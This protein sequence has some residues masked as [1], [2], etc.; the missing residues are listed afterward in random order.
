MKTFC[1]ALD[2]HDDPDLIAEYK[3]YHELENIWPQVLDCIRA[4]GILREEIYLAG[5]RLVLILQTMDEFSLDAKMAA[6]RECPEMQKWEKL[7]WKFQKPLPFA[8][9]G[10]KWVLMEKIFEV[11]S[12]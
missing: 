4:D 12:H 9:P 3:R 7:M 1:F 5:N 2:L 10:E 8:R 11:R 6:D